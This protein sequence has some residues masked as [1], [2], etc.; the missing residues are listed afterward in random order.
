MTPTTETVVH[1]HPDERTA[2]LQRRMY[3]PLCGLLTSVGGLLRTRRA[4]G[5]FLEG[6]ELTGVHVLEGLPAPKPNAYHIGGFGIQPFESRIRVLGEAIER[7][8]GHAAAF[9]GTFT[10]R[11]A[12]YTELAAA[13]EP[14]LPPE[15]FGVFLPGQYER[16]GFPFEPFDPDRP[17]GWL[18]LPSLSGGDDERAWI[19]AQFFLLGYVPRQDE[20]WLQSAVTT[21]TGA[22]TSGPNAL[23][24]AL[25][26]LVQ[27]DAALGHW[28]GTGTGVRILPDARTRQLDAIIARRCA[29][30]PRPE[31]HL[32][33]SADL[34]GLCVA[35]IL[36]ATPGA[37]P[38][39]AVGL[40]SGGRLQRVMYQALLEAVGVQSFAAWTYVSEGR[41]EGRDGDKDIYDLEGNVARYA[42][43]QG[44]DTVEKRFAQST[45]A[46]AGSLP[47]DDERPDRERLKDIVT[48]FRNT[49]K[50]LYHA[51]LTTVDIRQLG[52][53][54]HR[55]WSPDTLSLCFPGAPPAAHRRFADYGGFADRGPHPYP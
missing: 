23:R 4:P 21:G 51:D 54:A 6:A 10:V 52:F 9:G 29:G 22:H 53:A 31:F 45:A 37:V 7:Y 28:Y 11:H 27:V 33:P 41:E 20:P 35:C 2:A 39:V 49:G 12:S 48:A 24:S 17:L 15:A 16:P 13:G 14:V 47:P 50:R 8:A 26:E 5:F 18:L 42:A 25:E 38:A 30:R 55:V 34:P 32:L 19:P 46:P 43:P 40:G 44:A 3:S 1:R 36:R